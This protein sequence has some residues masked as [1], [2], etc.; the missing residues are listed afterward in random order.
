MGRSG[1][2]K[3][4]DSEDQGRFAPFVQSLF[5]AAWLSSKPLCAG[6]LMGDL[7]FFF[8]EG[9]VGCTVIITHVRDL[10]SVGDAEN[11]YDT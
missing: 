5:L 1:G 11:E 3:I 4:E 7:W 8:W 10:S 2:K 6:V 9:F